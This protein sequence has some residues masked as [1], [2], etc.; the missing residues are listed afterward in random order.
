MQVKVEY[1]KAV[2]IIPA[3]LE[4]VLLPLCPPLQRNLVLVIYVFSTG[5]WG[6]VVVKVLCF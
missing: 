1:L 3:M 2:H 5:A 4:P 6:N